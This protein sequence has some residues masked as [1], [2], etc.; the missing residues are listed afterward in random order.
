[1]PEAIRQ[2]EVADS[3]ERATYAAD[4]MAPDLDWHRPHNVEL[5]GLL[6]A[7]Q[8]RLRDAERLLRE[9]RAL[10]P[11]GPFGYVY[12]RTLPELLI[13]RGRSAEAEPMLA[14]L[15]GDTLPGPRA[16][17]HALRGHVRLADGRAADA[18]ADLAVA[19]SAL[20]RGAPIEAFYF[21]PYL[22]LLRGAVAL[23]DGH[24]ARGDSLL[25]A[26]TVA[27]RA[28]PGPDGWVV[29]LLAH[30]GA[31]GLARQAGAWELVER[32]ARAFV[33]H[34]PSYA[35]AHH[36]LAMAAERRGDA[37]TARAAYG[38]ALAFW[39]G[40]DADLPERAEAARALARLGT[41]APRAGAPVRE[42]YLAGA[43]GARLFYRVEGQGADTIVVLHGGPGSSHQYMRAHLGALAE[44]HVVIHYDQRGGGRSTLYRD[45]AA[46]AHPHFVADLEQVRRH[47]ALGRMT[48]LG[49]SWGGWLAALYAL[50][51]PGRVARLV[52]VAPGPPARDPF[53]AETHREIGRRLAARLDAGARARVDSLQRAM[54]TTEDPAAVCRTM[55]LLMAPAFVTRPVETIRA[56][57][58][59]DGTPEAIRRSA[60]TEA[61]A[62]RS[63]GAFDF[64]PRVRALRIPTLVVGGAEDPY[65]TGAEAWSTALPMARLVM[66]PDAGHS[67]FL[68]QPEAFDRAVAAFLTSAD[69]RSTTRAARTT[70]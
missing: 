27:A 58:F 23:A 32:L 24:G 53:M 15:V 55:G 10:R 46:L 50:E 37:A 5:L 40:A 34:A 7:H 12:L 9:G 57:D 45:S 66:V 11:G 41:G 43:G 4:A 16:V 26:A 30:D 29:S 13:T 33:A 19:E 62:E 3:I 6:Y 17:G 65:R 39:Q 48:L 25:V 69:A 47:F 61:L 18:R 20:A 2:L 14:S 31:I 49:H 63:L 44:R 54:A 8:G 70:P 21:A 51:H 28:L 35:P 36:A 64:R 60:A 59:C 52:L 67:P 1:V 22:E 68:D 38:R 56:E 42:G